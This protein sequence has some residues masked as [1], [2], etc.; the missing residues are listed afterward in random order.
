MYAVCVQ[1]YRPATTVERVAPELVVDPV[2]LV[3]KTRTYYM[4]GASPQSSTCTVKAEACTFVPRIM[5]IVR[6]GVMIRRL[7]GSPSNSNERN[8]E[9]AIGPQLSFRDTSS[10]D[11]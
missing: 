7:D 4:G 3:N 9:V 8:P 6:R 11:A 2:T 5:V 10:A 1:S